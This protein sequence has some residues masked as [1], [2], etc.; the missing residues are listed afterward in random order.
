MS[1][2]VASFD[3]VSVFCAENGRGVSRIVFKKTFVR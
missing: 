1:A 3:T 2:G